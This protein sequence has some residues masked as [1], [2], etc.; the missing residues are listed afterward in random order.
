MATWNPFEAGSWRPY[1]P[2]K[3]TSQPSYFNTNSTYGGSQWQNNQPTQFYSGLRRE[4]LQNNPDAT[5]SMFVAPFASGTDHFSGWVRNQY[6]QMQDAYKGALSMNPDLS[7]QQFL[8]DFGQGGMMQRYRAMAPED[9]G[10]RP[11]NF[12]GGRMSW[13]G[14]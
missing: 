3:Q 10:M 11:G 5:Y 13:F 7:Y 1:Q 4:Y 14:T 8:T 2:A 9:R 12:G 6:G